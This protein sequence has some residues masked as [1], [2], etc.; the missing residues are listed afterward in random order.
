MPG[1]KTRKS[2][3][4]KVDKKAERA[5]KEHVPQFI[6]SSVDSLEAAA[7]AL[8]GAYQAYNDAY[9]KEFG[10]TAAKKA[11]DKAFALVEKAIELCK[12]NKFYDKH[13]GPWTGV[14]SK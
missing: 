5:K 1:P 12:Q 7:D 3:T 13:E 10:L 2:K 9:Y 4:Q 6:N 11:S 14:F 8:S